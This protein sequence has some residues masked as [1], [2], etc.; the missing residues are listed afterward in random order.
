MIQMYDQ[1][2]LPDRRPDYLP[3][4]SSRLIASLPSTSQA[5]STATPT[6]TATKKR[7]K[8]SCST[9]GCKGEGHK[10]PTRWAEGHTTR[11]GCPHAE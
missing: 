6:T 9:P 1:F 8:S 5:T 3:A 7:K 10:N 4:F 2:I 11:A